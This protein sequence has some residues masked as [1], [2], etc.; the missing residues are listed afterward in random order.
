MQEELK[1]QEKA[2][3]I[4]IGRESL[5]I[6]SLLSRSLVSGDK[7]GTLPLAKRALKKVPTP[8]VSNRQKC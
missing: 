6:L 8:E 4:W 1:V 7:F 3:T 5:P 2:F